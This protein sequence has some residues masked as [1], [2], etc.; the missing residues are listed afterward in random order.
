MTSDSASRKTPYAPQRDRPDVVEERAR[1]VEKQDDLD[2]A[3]LVFIDEAGCHPGIGPLRGW[4]LRGQLLP[5]PEQSYARGQ[6]VSMVAAFRA[7]DG[8]CAQ[9]TVNGGVKARDFLRFV[10]AH[11]VPVL[12]AGDL[13]CWDNINM[14]KNKQV[15]AAIEAVGVS[16]ASLGVRGRTRAEA[17][18]S[19]DDMAKA[20][21]G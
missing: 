18:Q 13:V 10:N 9:M 11:L 4:A 5:G 20:L 15:L 17:R 21:L 7:S 2:G 14:H 8:I 16:W 6:H 12:R 19:I 1:F 3:R